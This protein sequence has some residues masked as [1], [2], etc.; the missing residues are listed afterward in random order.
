M[1]TDATSRRRLRP[2]P[3]SGAG[4]DLFE[5]VV[6]LGAAFAAGALMIL[7]IGHNPISA[8]RALIQSSI[9]SRK[10]I[11]ETLES[12]TPLVFA[13][14]AFAIAFRAR[15]LNLGVGSQILV[16]ALVAAWLG[17]A[18]ALPKVLHIA[19]LVV[20]GALGGALYASI[21][22]ALKAYRGV[23]EVIST[24]M[25]EYVALS[26][27]NYLVN[28]PLQDPRDAGLPQTPQILDSARLPRILPPS[29]L[30]AGVFVLIATGALV[31]WIRDRSRI[32]FE[33]AA[34][35]AG[36]GAAKHA[37]ISTV[38]ATMT[39]MATSGAVAGVAGAVLMSGLLHR[40]QS[41]TGAGLGLSGLAIALLSRQRIVALFLAGILFGALAQGQRGMQ[42]AAGVP[43]DMLAVLQGFIVFFVAAPQ[44]LWAV[45][46]WRTQRRATAEAGTGA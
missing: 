11:G 3:D 7:L 12:S 34:V 14:L 4:R 40:Y 36:P 43:Q 42:Q 35:G 46:R 9:G 31:K 23:H 45:E 41:S 16:G 22:G 13:G 32:G 38:R 6:L 25:L 24:I 44:I 5:A 29:R 10:A 28:G 26:M 20:A 8:Y 37:G 30:S 15:L 18:V 27:I 19:V 17:S 21:A 2:R 1:T 33:W 39:A